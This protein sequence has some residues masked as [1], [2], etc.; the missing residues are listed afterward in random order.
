MVRYI[1]G[2]SLSSGLMKSGM[3]MVCP[4]A[5]AFSPSLPHTVGE[6]PFSSAGPMTTAP[7]PSPNRK[8][9]DRE[10]TSRLNDIVSDPISSTLVALPA[11]ISALATDTP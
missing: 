9:V 8:A 1:P 4:M 2:F 6:M 3:L 7:A 10:V 5:E 11:L